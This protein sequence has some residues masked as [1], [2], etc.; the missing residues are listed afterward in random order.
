MLNRRDFLK[1]VGAVAGLFGLGGAS[2]LVG[3]TQPDPELPDPELPDPEL[4]KAV[5]EAMQSGLRVAFLTN[6]HLRE[7]GARMQLKKRPGATW[8]VRQ[9]C[10]RYEEIWMWKDRPVCL[11]GCATRSFDPAK[12]DCQEC[13]L[14]EEKR[15]IK[16]L[17]EGNLKWEPVGTYFNRT[18]PYG[19]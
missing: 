12:P 5:Y 7:M 11:G 8:T 15:I 13:F 9:F 18:K 2:R 19:L 3:T 16:M 17:N 1:G 6:P 10:I 4:D 14:R